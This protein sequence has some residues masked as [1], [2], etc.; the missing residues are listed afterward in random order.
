MGFGLGFGLGLVLVLVLVLGCVGCVWLFGCPVFTLVCLDRPCAGPH[1][2]FFARAKKSRQKKA[3]LPRRF[4]ASG[5]HQFSGSGPRTFGVA[6][7]FFPVARARTSRPLRG[8]SLL[9]KPIF[10]T[11]LA[12]RFDGSSGRTEARFT[13]DDPSAFRRFRRFDWSGILRATNPAQ[14]WKV[15]FVT[16]GVQRANDAER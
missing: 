16:D 1:L 11:P 2:L 6:G 7:P 14:A 10:A 3:R 13:P 4:V 9:Q 5:V 12:S 15:G 8:G